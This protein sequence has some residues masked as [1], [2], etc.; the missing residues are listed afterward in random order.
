MLLCK[1]RPFALKEYVPAALNITIYDTVNVE[2]ERYLY[3]V[4]TVPMIGGMYHV[5]VSSGYEA[6]TS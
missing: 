3:A 5:A 4:P 6:E 1:T 2:A